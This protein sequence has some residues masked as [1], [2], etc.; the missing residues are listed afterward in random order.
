M[1]LE[2]KNAFASIEILTVSLGERV[3]SRMSCTLSP[4]TPAVP[5]L[6]LA[7]RFEVPFAVTRN[8]SGV[9]VPIGSVISR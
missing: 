9:Q 2:S 6:Q 8:L 4:G 5:K 1:A 3:S 7:T